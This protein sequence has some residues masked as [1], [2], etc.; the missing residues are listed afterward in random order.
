MSLNTVLLHY[1]DPNMNGFILHSL[2]GLP[3]YFQVI[4]RLL[5]HIVL[6]TFFQTGVPG[7]Y[8]ANSHL[9]YLYIGPVLKHL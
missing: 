5:Q 2:I 1:P 6:H 3:A 4:I 9:E 7:K 8:S